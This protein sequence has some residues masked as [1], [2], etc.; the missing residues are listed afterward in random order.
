M[1]LIKTIKAQLG[2]SNTATQNFTL[3]AEAADGTMKLARG[4]AG[5]TTQDI[6]TVASTG[7]VDFPQL[8]RS[9]TPN[10]YVKLPSGL[11]LQW[12][13][14]SSTASSANNINVTF[15]ITFPNA[16]FQVQG[17]IGLGNAAGNYTVQTSIVN[18]N[19]AVLTAQNNGAYSSG[20]SI[21]WFAIGY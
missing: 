2:L 9:L 18:T 14:S 4:N 17:S 19:N 11:I 15:P 16:A 6:I 1:S 5:A 20:I 7:A 3:T 13:T 8:A 10:G 12:G 21:L